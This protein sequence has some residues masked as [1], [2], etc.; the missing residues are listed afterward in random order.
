MSRQY[1]TWLPASSNSLPQI[2][3][4]DEASQPEGHCHELDRAIVSEQ[5]L[6]EVK[7]GY[8]GLT[9]DVPGCQCPISESP[10]YFARM[11]LPRRESHCGELGIWVPAK[12]ISCTLFRKSDVCDKLPTWMVANM[13][14][15]KERVSC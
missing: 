14:G 11:R 1:F 3:C 8:T 7:G 2:L 4:Q 12:L 15:G 5:S 13:E 9:N 10:E 6:E